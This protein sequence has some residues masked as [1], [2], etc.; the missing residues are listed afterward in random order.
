[1]N[2]TSH[3]PRVGREQR[4]SPS[5]SAS[6]FP[7]GLTPP[8]PWVKSTWHRSKSCTARIK[9]RSW[10]HSS[11]WPA[12]TRS[13]SLC[14]SAKRFNISCLFEKTSPALLCLKAVSECLSKGEG[15]DVLHL[16]NSAGQQSLTPC[17]LTDTNLFKATISPILPCP[18]SAHSVL[19]KGQGCARGVNLP[20]SSF[21]Q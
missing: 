21:P 6:E 19:L 5:G 7:P 10:V 11:P 14:H 9:G 17:F 12:I 1:M 18:G 3:G 13:Q 8:V 16:L 20:Y 15:T 4:C 2:T